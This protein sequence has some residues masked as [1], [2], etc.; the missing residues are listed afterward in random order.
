MS[1]GHDCLNTLRLPHVNQSVISGPFEPP[2]PDREVSELTHKS[3]SSTWFA[4]PL[5]FSHHKVNRSHTNK[6]S[7]GASFSFISNCVFTGGLMG[8][9][10]SSCYLLENHKLYPYS[11]RE[12]ESKLLHLNNSLTIFLAIE[13]DK[14]GRFWY[15]PS[16]DW[17]RWVEAQ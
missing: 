7:M 8:L 6:E 16:T 14:D 3:K 1:Y 9:C 10:K 5:K 17:V 15:F 13:W 4:I 2:P 12:R 11:C